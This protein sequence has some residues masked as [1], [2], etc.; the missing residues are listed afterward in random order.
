MVSLF[1][2]DFR[3][4]HFMTSKVWPTKLGIDT[5]VVAND[6]V[7]GDALRT[8]L[9]RM[10]A[11]PTSELF[12]MTV[13]DAA[14]WLAGDQDESRHVELLVESTADALS[15]V[16]VVPGLSEL[17]VALT[18]GGEGKVMLTPSLGFA[19]ED[20]ENM[21]EILAAGVDAQAYVAPDDRRVPM[22]E[23]L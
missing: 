9:I 13:D 18:P 15:L 21:R 2:I 14:K 19:P 17:N 22:A 12:I 16:R 5:I 6:A 1:R 3:L 4:L 20:F 23:L 11:P 7:V 8:S 10:S